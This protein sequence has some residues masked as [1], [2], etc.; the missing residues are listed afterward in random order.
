MVDRD[1]RALACVSVTAGFDGIPRH[2]ACVPQ[3]HSP[4]L[5][6]SD[7]DAKPMVLLLGQYSVGK[8]SF[9]RFLLGRDYPGIRI[10]APLAI[11]PLF[12]HSS[13]SSCSFLCDSVV[14]MGAYE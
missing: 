1:A 7:F 12:T 5:R 11:I 6:A 3:F 9:I 4:Y 13:D 8:T 14:F 10:G 2:A